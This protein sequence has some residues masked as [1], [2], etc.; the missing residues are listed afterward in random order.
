MTFVD[1]RQAAKAELL[2]AASPDKAI[3]IDELRFPPAATATSAGMVFEVDATLD[4][5]AE[6]GEL[7]PGMEG[8]VYMDL[9]DRNAWWVLTHRITDWLKMR[10]WI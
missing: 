9:G 3:E 10:F 6:T 8:V 2:L 1:A 4:V 5:N 7:L